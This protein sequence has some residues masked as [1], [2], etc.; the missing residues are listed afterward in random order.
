[1]NKEVLLLSKA[2]L[3]QATQDNLL[4]L[5]EYLKNFAKISAKAGYFKSADI[6]PV[7]FDIDHFYENFDDIDE[8][9][10]QTSACAVGH[11]AVM[12]GYKVN[13]DGVY[14]GEEGMEGWRWFSTNVI[15]IAPQGVHERAWDWIFGGSW[16][17]CDNT[18]LGVVARIKHYLAHGVPDNFDVGS[19]GNTV[20]AVAMMAHY[21]PI[22]ERLEAECAAV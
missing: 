20:E 1:M 5:S 4:E 11:F 9:E 19:C 10:C 15:G 17:E 18:P 2:P 3:P 6:I 7:A 8:H 14:M 16:A 13:E 22:R 12:R 21:L